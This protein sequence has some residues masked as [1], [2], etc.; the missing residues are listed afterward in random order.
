VREGDGVVTITF[1]PDAGTCPE[2]P[3]APGAP[4][5][6]AAV[7]AEPRF[8]GSGAAPGESSRVPMVEYTH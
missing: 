5:A 4:A 7:A 1:D 2:E 6:P 3:V 8:T